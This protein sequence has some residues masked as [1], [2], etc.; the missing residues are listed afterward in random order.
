MI[1]EP[2]FKWGADLDVTKYIGEHRFTLNPK[3]GEKKVDSEVV[4]KYY[5]NDG[6]SLRLLK[7]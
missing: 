6:C 5:N 3:E 4:W 7:P 1:K 2:E